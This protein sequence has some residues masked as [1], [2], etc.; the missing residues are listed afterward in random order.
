MFT[1]RLVYNQVP[2]FP[3]AHPKDIAFFRSSIVLT[4]SI[5]PNHTSDVQMAIIIIRPMVPLVK[6]SEGKSHVPWLDQVSEDTC[7]DRPLHIHQ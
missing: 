4:G 2:F 5:W 7:L 1:G 3:D 6:R